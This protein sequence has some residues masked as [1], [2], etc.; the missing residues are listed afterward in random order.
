MMSSKN[1]EFRISLSSA[2]LLEVEFWN[3]RGIAKF[4]TALVSASRQLVN[5]NLSCQV[6]PR[7]WWQNFSNDTL[8]I[9]TKNNFK[10]F[11][12][13]V[14]LERRVVRCCLLWE[15]SKHSNFGVRRRYAAAVEFGVHKRRF[16]SHELA[17]ND[18]QRAPQGSLQHRL[19]KRKKRQFYFERKLGLHNQA[20]GSKLHDV[21]LHLRRPLEIGLQCNVFALNS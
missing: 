18:L 12:S 4:K 6:L 11:F 5:R 3:Q 21:A 17:S 16:A 19:D 9:L 20:L 13:D 14:P 2:F 15:R 7:K 8:K 1:W 10:N